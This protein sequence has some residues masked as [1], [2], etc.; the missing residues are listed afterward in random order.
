MI[1]RRDLLKL[2]AAGAATMFLVPRTS[3]AQAACGVGP[4]LITIEAQNAWDPTFLCDPKTNAAFTPWV[5]GD[6][7]TASGIQY[8]PRLLPDLTKAPYITNGQDFFVKHASR[9]VVVNGVDN[10]TVSHD[11]GPRVAF[12]G[13]NREGVPTLAGLVAAARG[14][15]LPMSLLTTGGFV[16]TEGLVPI[17]RAGNVNV[18][19][20]LAR[21][22][23]AN[24]TSTSPRNIH[25]PSVFSMLRE[26]VQ[27]RD[28]RRAA[29]AKVPREVAG[30]L[31][32]APSRAA[33]MNAQ[34]DSLE[35]ALDAA[36]SVSSTNPIIPKAAACMAAMAAGAC[37]AAHFET[38]ESFDTHDNHDVDHPLAMQE[39]LELVDFVLDTANNT[40]ALAER[41]V[42]VVVGS[43]FGRTRYNDDAGK[44]HWPV[45]S[46]MIAAAGAATSLIQG[47]R[48]V[49]KTV[50]QVD[51]VTANGLVARKVKLDSG[52]VIEAGDDDPQGI[53]LQAGHVHLALREALG[54]CKDDPNDLS[55]KF[56]LTTIVPA[57]ALPILKPA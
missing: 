28:Q 18:L 21:S 14:A 36:S 16:N 48:V 57:D 51:G 5:S 23:V 45:T 13:S 15:T 7:R 47:G 53:T 37:A 27:Q 35:E 39:L 50:T 19:L 40:P 38:Q 44:D 8:A 30:I 17:T 22:N 42:L 52:D 9:M 3:R 34:F 31:R 41:G 11:I 4:L 24:F 20:G 32:V 12:A 56:P 43:D 33:E 49:G 1:S 10:A 25:D 46:M 6:L 2:S 54:F 55:A 26:R 29:A